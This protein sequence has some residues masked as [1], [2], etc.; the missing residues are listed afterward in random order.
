MLSV[1]CVGLESPW[2]G[3]VLYYS[4]HQTHNILKRVIMPKIKTLDHLHKITWAHIETHRPFNRR[5]LRDVFHCSQ[6][7]KIGKDFITIGQRKGGNK[8]VF[9]NEARFRVDYIWKHLGV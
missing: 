3:S 9:P 4:V 2:G 6:C 1:S 5:I 7:R 8:P